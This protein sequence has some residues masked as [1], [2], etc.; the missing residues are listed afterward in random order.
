MK[1][2]ILMLIIG[3][4]IGAVITAGCFLVFTK[5]STGTNQNGNMPEMGNFVPGEKPNGMRHGGD[6]TNMPGDN[7]ENA[8]NTTTSTTTNTS[9]NANTNS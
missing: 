2:K 1:D 7:S 9:T 4:L 3:I 6:T 8:S 5:N